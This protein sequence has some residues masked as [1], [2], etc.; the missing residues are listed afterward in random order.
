MNDEHLDDHGADTVHKRRK[1]WGAVWEQPS[2]VM[3]VYDVT[4]ET[5]FSSC[6][7]WLERV[8]AMKPDTNIPGVVLANKIDLD[9]RRVVS[10]KEGK[11][12]AMQ[13]G[14]EY[15]E[16]SAKEMQNV[17]TPFFYMAHEFHKLYQEQLQ[18]FQSL[19]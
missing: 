6:V 10:P 13:H 15:F 12:L 8:R 7:K 5:S 1:Q 4:E 14:L 19:T 18:V 2:L 17:D 3:V 16:C 11:D 9:Q